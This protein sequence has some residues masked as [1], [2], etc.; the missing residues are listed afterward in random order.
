MKKNKIS[1]IAIV[2]LLIFSLMGCQK[3]AGPDPDPKPDDVAEEALAN[4]TIEYLPEDEDIT[5]YISFTNPQY[6]GSEYLTSLK[7]T[8]D[9]KIS[10]L[11][12]RA[13]EEGHEENGVRLFFIDHTIYELDQLTPE[14]PLAFMTVFP[15]FMPTLTLTYTDTDQKEKSVSICMSGDDSSLVIR[16]AGFED[17]PMPKEEDPKSTTPANVSMSFLSEDTTTDKYPECYEFSDPVYNNK[18]YQNSILIVTDSPISKVKIIDAELGEETNG[19][20]SG[21][22]TKA[23]IYELPELTAE[24]PLIYNTEFPGDMPSRLISYVDATGEEKIFSL[25][26]SGEDGSL[27][28]TPAFIID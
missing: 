14:K 22:H 24:K 10:N 5:N 25:S 26:M 20:L 3:T 8:T 6:E 2:L 18:T 1:Y 13:V 16:P 23:E 27:V 28:T 19:D 11:K 4:V 17:G 21:F 9:Q 7:I 12:F 15:N